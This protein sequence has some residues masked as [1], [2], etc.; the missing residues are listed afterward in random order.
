ML[1][2]ILLTL[3]VHSAFAEGWVYGQFNTWYERS[4]G[5]R[6]T[7]G[8]YSIDGE[9]YIFDIDGNRVFNQWTML[10]DGE[11]YYSLSDGKVAKNQW[12]ND[13]FYVDET[14]AMVRDK[15]YNGDYFDIDGFRTDP[16][17]Y[18]ADPQAAPIQLSLPANSAFNEIE[19]ENY[20]AG[21]VVMAADEGGGCLGYIEN[22]DYA[23]YYGLDFGDGAYTF[24]ANATSLHD[25]GNIELHLDSM[26]GPVIGTCNITGTESWEAW[27]DFS[28]DIE[29]TWGVHDLY[30]VFR[31]GNGYL[32]N[33][34][35]FYFTSP[36]YRV[37]KPVLKVFPA[38]RFNDCSGV[39]GE[40]Y[41]ANIGY[42]ENGDW[43][44]YKEIDF[45]EGPG[46][47][48][49]RASALHDGGTIE[50]RLDGIDGSLIGSCP[51]TNTGGWG[52]YHDFSC[53]I[54]NG[55]A[56]NARIH[57]LYLVFRGGSGY[58]FNIQLFWFEK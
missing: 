37:T 35:F 2:I 13:T 48:A 6:L 42:I 54:S 33:I 52:Y 28:C 44:L 19:A 16:Q 55:F 56:S 24:T 11:R 49:V 15:W 4:D 58:L 53:G 40:N 27:R 12:I 46:T 30:L 8:K 10:T 5:S 39:F 51:V 45:G 41:G 18:F 22:G 23:A 29:P 32:F 9:D 50:F 34:N 17:G 38:G 20:D 36:Y 57:D 31:G 1:L 21:S 43:V 14:G 3:A 47:A 25:G 7:N 26:T